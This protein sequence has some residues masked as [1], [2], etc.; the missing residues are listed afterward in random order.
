MLTIFS[1]C[2]DIKFFL[3]AKQTVVGGNQNN[4]MLYQWNNPSQ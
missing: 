4:G 2:Q 3:L 1:L